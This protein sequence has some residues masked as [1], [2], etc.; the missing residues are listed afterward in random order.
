MGVRSL[1]QQQQQRYGHV[2]S[3][4]RGAAGR[5]PR[6]PASGLRGR[7]IAGCGRL[8][9]PRGELIPRKGGYARDC[10]LPGGKARVKN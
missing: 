2:A 5:R 3:A 6:L 10:P 8:L 4:G 7:R 9:G 1:L